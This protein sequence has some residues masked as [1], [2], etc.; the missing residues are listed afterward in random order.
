M[1]SQ[2]SLFNLTQWLR[3]NRLAPVLTILAAG[4]AIALSLFEIVNFSVA[5]NIL[6]ALLALLALDALSERIG[7]LERIETKLGYLSG[8]GTLKTQTDLPSVQEQAS[9]ATEICIGAVSASSLFIR[10]L[11]F[12]ESKLKDGCK[13]RV[14]LLDPNASSVP[15]WDSLN[16]ISLTQADIEKTLA[17]LKELML[18]NNTKGKC[19]VRLSNI[20]LPFSIFGFNMRKETG[21]ITIAY[22]NYRTLKG[23]A[24]VVLTKSDNS[25]WFDFYREQ[26]EQAWEEAVVWSPNE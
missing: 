17:I 21:V 2:N 9:H 4:T 16:K 3:P 7:V 13:I 12:F 22:P 10:N 25:V 5:E 1:K 18:F 15:I 23:R 20:F 26:F 11:D 8:G 14:I 24:H 6:I 19:E